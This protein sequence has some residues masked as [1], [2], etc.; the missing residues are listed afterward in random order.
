MGS[1]LTTNT[2]C[3]GMGNCTGG[4][5]TAC[6][7]NLSCANA[8]RCNATCTNDTQCASGYH[9]DGALCRLPLG[10]GSACTSNNICA[11]GIC[12]TNG[13]GRCCTNACIEGGSCGAT[14]CSTTGA[15]EYPGVST[16]CPSTTSGPMCT[17]GMLTNG[18]DGMG[19]CDL[20]PTPCPNGFACASA[21]ACLTSCGSTAGNNADCQ[22]NDYCDG[23]NGGACQPMIGRGKPC[24]QSYQCLNG[25]CS[26]TPMVCN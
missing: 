18:C 22:A 8:T 4:T 13:T 12:G 24:T 7:N 17:G 25:T 16:P 3:D 2:Q 23:L 9:C 1:M 6:L 5:P 14:G 10:P 26:G 21:T 11:S 15:C 20:T 19:T